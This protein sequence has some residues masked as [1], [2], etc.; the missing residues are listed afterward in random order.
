MS[1]SISDLFIL[2]YFK[3]MRAEINMR[4]TTHTTLVTAKIF[5]VGAMLAFMIANLTDQN[6]KSVI[7]GFLLLPII[8]MLYDIMI[9]KNIH[10]IHKIG[11][12]IRD[13]LEEK[14]YKIEMWE[15]YAG[16]LN[17]K[18][19]CYGLADILFLGLFTFGT[20]VVA[21]YL[22]YVNGSERIGVITGA[23]FFI[24]LIFVLKYM[25]RTILYFRP[26][27]AEQSGPPDRKS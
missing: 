21:S 8:A 20:I 27:K 26:I 10:N 13:I 19:R 6:K 24:I 23:I 2:E 14:L 16:Q 4:I 9:A 17:P 22:L 1:E 3:E 11:M 12:F 15:H 7:F 5:S 25:R 18:T